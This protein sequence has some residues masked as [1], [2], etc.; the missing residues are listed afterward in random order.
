MTP[1][2]HALLDGQKAI[3]KP[4]KQRKSVCG[5]EKKWMQKV[6]ASFSQ[7][8]SGFGGGAV[9]PVGRVSAS[10]RDSM[11]KEAWE[12]SPSPPHTLPCCT[13]HL[14]SR[15]QQSPS[16]KACRPGGTVGPAQHC[17]KEQSSCAQKRRNKTQALNTCNFFK[18]THL[19][20][21]NLYVERW[22]DAPYLQERKEL[23]FM[24]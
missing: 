17:N 19:G 11:S 5:V 16:R 14:S 9:T 2:H 18:N 20:H 4:H 13:L 10:P 23:Q 7:W 24:S 8:L 3:G 15:L 6:C 22:A 1:H 21:K 12:G